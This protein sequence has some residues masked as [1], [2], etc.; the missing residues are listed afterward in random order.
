M[1]LILRIFKVFDLMLLNKIA[2][3]TYSDHDQQWSQEMSATNLGH[4]LC[5]LHLASCVAHPVSFTGDGTPP[6]DSRP[7]SPAAALQQSPGDPIM[8]EVCLTHLHFLFLVSASTRFTSVILQS[9]EELLDVK[10]NEHFPY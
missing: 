1:F 5:H 7:S 9:S 3:C 8:P 10:K 6:G 2:N 4:K